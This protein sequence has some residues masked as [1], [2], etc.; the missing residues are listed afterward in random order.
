MLSDTSALFHSWLNSKWISFYYKFM[1]FSYRLVLCH[2]LCYAKQEEKKLML[3]PKNC[4]QYFFHYECNCLPYMPHWQ[5]HDI[6]SFSH[7]PQTIVFS[8]ISIST[9]FLHLITFSS[10]KS[11]IPTKNFV[12][13]THPSPSWICFSLTW[14]LK[15]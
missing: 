8:W 12:H 10:L 7:N 11:S 6:Y 3:F 14:W 5:S 13:H 15:S 9:D 2:Y 4:S 1:T